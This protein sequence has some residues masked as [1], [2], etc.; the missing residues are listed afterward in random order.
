MAKI[1]QTPENRT[2][3]RGKRARELLGQAKDFYKNR[4]YIPC[5]DRCE[6]L[7]GSYGDLAEGV[8]ASQIVNEI[9]NNPEWLQSA[10]DIMSDRLGGIYLALAD[11]L[12]K[13]NQPQ[14]AEACLQRVIQAFP[15]SSTAKRNR[16]PFGLDN[17]KVCRRGIWSWAAPLHRRDLTNIMFQPSP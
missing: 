3:E 6:W 2:L 10:A 11:S 9:K 13:K 1:S 5:L 4:E 14:Q 15:G 16:R 7:V 12:L 8:E 17:C